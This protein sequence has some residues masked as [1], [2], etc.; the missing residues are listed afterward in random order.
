VGADRFK[1]YSEDDAR[2]D[3]KDQ[4]PEP[5]VLP[6]PDEAPSPKVQGQPAAGDLLVQWGQQWWPAEVVRQDGSS[7]LI[8]Y[9][10]YGDQWDEWVTPER[11]GLFSGNQ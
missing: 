5:T 2:K 7:Y 8:H 10:G 3:R 4:L 6:L 9:K 1:L 11:L